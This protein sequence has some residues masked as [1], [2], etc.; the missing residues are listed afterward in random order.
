LRR[1]DSKQGAA[2][3]LALG[4]DSVGVPHMY[5]VD[6]IVVVAVV[7]LVGALVVAMRRVAGCCTRIQEEYPR[8]AADNSRKRLTLVEA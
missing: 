4:G 5:I 7:V 8:L 1:V 6:S 3:F 2:H